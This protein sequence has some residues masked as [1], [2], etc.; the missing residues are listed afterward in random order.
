MMRGYLGCDNYFTYT[1]SSLQVIPLHKALKKCTPKLNF[2][3]K[4]Y[5]A[6]ALLA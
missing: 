6:Q 3:M 1:I 5:G 2:F 4:I